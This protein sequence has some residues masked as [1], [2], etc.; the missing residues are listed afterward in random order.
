MRDLKR[1]GIAMVFIT[2]FIDQ[3]YEIADRI[4]VLRNGRLVG[5]A[6]SADLPPLKLISLMLGRELERTEERLAAAA[7]TARGEP[8]LVAEGVGRRR[9]MAPFD[10]SIRPG[11]VV[12]LAGLLGSGR[13]EV[14]K[15]IFG[16]VRGGFGTPQRRRARR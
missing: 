4:S 9:L 5:S 13:T 10:L 14:A 8:I 16:A 11:E 6:A 7:S 12:G 3:V 2:H 15:L 1:R